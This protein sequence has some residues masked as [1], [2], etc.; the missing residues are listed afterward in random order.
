MAGEFNILWAL[1]GAGVVGGTIYAVASS[2][3]TPAPVAP[4]PVKLKPRASAVN[5]GN[6]FAPAVLPPAEAP[7]ANEPIATTVPLTQVQQKSLTDWENNAATPAEQRV[8][9]SLTADQIASTPQDDWQG[10]TD[11][12]LEGPV[13]GLSLATATASVQATINAQGFQGRPSTL[14]L[15]RALLPY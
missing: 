6:L 11:L 5:L 8:L 14:A 2:S 15:A 9:Q 4:P 10:L 1:L 12:T 7:N 3:P 13:D